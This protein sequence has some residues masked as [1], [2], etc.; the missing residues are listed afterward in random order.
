MEL[1]SE[2]R[3]VLELAASARQPRAE[4]KAL[5]ERRLALLLGTSAVTSLTAAQT[6]R[7][8]WA[9]ATARFGTKASLLKWGASSAVVL[10]AL[11]G[12]ALRSPDL[13][14]APA[15]PVSQTVTPAPT[16]S[17]EPVPATSQTLA[18]QSPVAATTAPPSMAAMPEAAP[19]THTDTSARARLPAAPK[20]R[21]AALADQLELL[22]QAQSAWRAG[23]PQRT[24]ALL[25][26]HRKS[27]PRSELQLE[28]DGLRILALCE[29]GQHTRARPLVQSLLRRA[30]D[31]P[32]RASI[33]R[34]CAQ[35]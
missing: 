35:R 5:V 3:R 13:S 15:R 8:G 23:Q 34:A 32:L 1:D 9:W 19:G 27:Y 18:P 2:A 30:P 20:Q 31:S 12:V 6:A 14:A 4:D 22:L 29:L 24:L 33:A 25:D 11:T 28:R 17:A 21:A 10:A 7:P 16:V 26:Q